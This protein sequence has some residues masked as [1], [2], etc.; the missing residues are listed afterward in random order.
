MKSF[1]SSPQ[2]LRLALQCTTI[3]S[4]IAALLLCSS[5]FA[6]SSGSIPPRAVKVAGSHSSSSSWGIWLFGARGQGCWGTQT[7][8]QG[9]VTGESVTCGY[10]VPG[11]RFQ[12]A[13]TGVVTGGPSPDSLLFFLVRSPEV[14]SLKVLVRSSGDA[15]RW[16]T[17]SAK[18]V[19]A[20]NREAARIPPHVGF[21]TRLIDGKS[22]CPRRV[23]AYDG[24][25]RRVGQGAL[26]ACKKS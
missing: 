6:A 15:A 2:S 26:P 12:L 18:R 1:E 22:V 20:S 21:G 17:I 19:S 11:D 10:S 24:N 14:E 16:V 7:K 13:A 3:V 9:D 8:H 4:A 25:H 23:V 5:T